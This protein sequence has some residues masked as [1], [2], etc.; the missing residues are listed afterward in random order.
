LMDGILQPPGTTDGWVEA[1][2]RNLVATI[3]PDPANPSPWTDGG[4][5][6]AKWGTWGRGLRPRE[7]VE[8]VVTHYVGQHRQWPYDQGPARQRYGPSAADS[9]VIPDTPQTE[10]AGMVVFDSIE[11]HPSSGAGNEEYVILRNASP[12]AVDLSG[13]SVSGVISH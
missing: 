2:M 1:Y 7:E 13:W 12:V 4:L 5:D 11:A 6:F 10:V 3:D 8:Y 9:D